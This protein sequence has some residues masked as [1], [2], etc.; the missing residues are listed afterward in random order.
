MSD[1]LVGRADAYSVSTQVQILVRQPKVKFPPN[2]R[3]TPVVVREKLLTTERVDY[4]I[5][6]VT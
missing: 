4:G 3:L 5:G 1:S 6:L 2:H